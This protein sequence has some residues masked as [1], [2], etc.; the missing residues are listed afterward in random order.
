[1][2]EVTNVLTTRLREEVKR[3]QQTNLTPEEREDLRLGNTTLTRW[4]QYY[5]PDFTFL[6]FGEVH[7]RIEAHADNHRAAIMAPRGSAKSTLLGAANALRLAALGRKQFVV[8]ISPEAEAHLARILNQIVENDRLLL[9][10]PHLR[11]QNLVDLKKQ[12]RRRRKETQA[13]F[14]TVG[15]VTFIAKGPGAAIRGMVRDGKRPDHVILDDIESRESAANPDRTRKLIDWVRTDIAGL[16]GPGYASMSIHAIGTPL[17]HYTLI[18]TLVDEWNGE[19]IP[20]HD[21][22]TGENMWPAGLGEDTLNQIRYGYWS[23]RTKKGEVMLPHDTSED[24]RPHYAAFVHGIGERAYQQEYEM[25]PV[26]EG[27]ADFQRAWFVGKKISTNDLKSLTLSRIV[28]AWDFAATEKTAKAIDPD[29][30]ASVKLGID[31][32]GRIIIMHAFQDRLSAS[33][34]ERAVELS[35]QMDGNRTRTLVPQDPGQ[36]GKAQ[37]EHYITK[38]LA[39]HDAR[40]VLQ[41]GD[42]RTRWQP[43]SAQAEI[44]NVYYVDGDWNEM[45]IDHLCLLP[46]GAHDDLGDAA[47]QAY[48]ELQPEQAA[49]GDTEVGY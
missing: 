41:S 12:R 22:I 36:A 40:A 37:A 17:A 31:Q 42:K 18:G 20:I 35:A 5:L 3:A 15:G 44:G 27:A 14:N 1:M 4:A 8:V 33:K 26:E 38:V 21:R 16:K 32:Y 30:T 29:Y 10:Y 47:G 28:R 43:F 19:I 25:R 7:A 13:E 39:G 23:Y 9:D 2:S 45:L 49:W 6:P 24:D 34:V 11:P 46:F 48:I